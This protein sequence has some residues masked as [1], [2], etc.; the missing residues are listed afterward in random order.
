MSDTFESF[1]DMLRRVLG[2]RLKPEVTTFTDMFATDGVLEY[3]FAPPGL[4]TPLVGRDA[5]V[6]NFQTLKKWFR[7]DSVTEVVVHE[8]GDSQ[9]LMIEFA[10]QGE[11]LMTK[12]P[13]NQRYISVIRVRDGH[14]VH[15]KDYWD[16][17]A[18]LRAVNGE[19]SMKGVALGV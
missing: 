6:A 19:E 12:Q 14:I 2:K 17:L 18:L 11:G 9:F 8:T 7:V 10:A 3:P 13:Y 5:I 1:P 4:K 15:Y 16:P